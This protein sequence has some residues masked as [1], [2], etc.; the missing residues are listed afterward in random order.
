[1]MTLCHGKYLT[2]LAVKTQ[3]S[4]AEMWLM[5]SC[6]LLKYSCMAILGS[7]DKSDLIFTGGY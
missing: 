3:W 4:V 1:M 5:S 2:T 6:C 7:G